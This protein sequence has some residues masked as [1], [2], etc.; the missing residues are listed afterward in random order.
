M[1]YEVAVIGAGPAGSTAAY[2]AVK[3]GLKTLLL[4][5]HRVA[6]TPPHCAGKLTV[7]AFSQFQLPSKLILNSVRGA[8]LLSPGG[9]EIQVSKPTYDSHIIDREALDRFLAS[10]AQNAGAEAMFKAK[11]SRIIFQSSGFLLK[12]RG[13]EVE[14]SLLVLAEGASGKLADALGF[15]SLPKVKGFQLELEGFEPRRKDFVEVFLGC[16]FF[17]GFFG[18]VIPLGD[19]KVRLGLCVSSRASPRVFLEKALKEHPCLSTRVGKAKILR[20]YGGLI[21][22]HGPKSATYHPRG[23]LLAGDVAGHV[24]STTGGGVYF[25]M[26]AGKLAGEAAS[27]AFDE[28]LEKGLR[29]YEKACLKAFGRELAFTSRVRSFL[30]SLSDKDLDEIFKL[31]SNREVIEVAQTYGDTAYQ[32]RVWKPLLKTSF[33][34]ALKKPRNMALLVKLSA[35]ILQSL[36]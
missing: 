15:P 3:S 13:F 9:L 16:K 34:M 19:G 18:W 28:G 12:G 17:P 29:G 31:A 23:I 10:R 1:K 24:K 7:K 6:G 2:H 8:F 22:L 20:T 21:P 27:H 30:N 33:K 32:S 11:V 26:M 5:E 4:E 25:G 14:T 36:L 35:K